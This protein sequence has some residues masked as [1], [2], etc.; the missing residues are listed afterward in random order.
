MVDE[1]NLRAFGDFRKRRMRAALGTVYL[2]S[3][4]KSKHRSPGNYNSPI[5]L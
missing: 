3:S 5:L 1:T 2:G 4:H